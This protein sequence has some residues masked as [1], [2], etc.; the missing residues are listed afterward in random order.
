[1]VGAAHFPCGPIIF[2]PCGMASGRP[3]VEVALLFFVHRNGALEPGITKVVR[4]YQ[5]TDSEAEPS[6]FTPKICG[7]FVDRIRSTLR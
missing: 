7:Q 4:E 3:Y 5:H 6:G 2:G 1:M